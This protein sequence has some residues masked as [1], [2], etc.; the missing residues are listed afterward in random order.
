MQFGKYLRVISINLRE[1]KRGYVVQDGLANVQPNTCLAW[2]VQIQ[3]SIEQ[4]PKS[5]TSTPLVH[6]WTN[7]PEGRQKNESN[8]TGPI[9][10]F[11]HNAKSIT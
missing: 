9:F 6:K 8:D 4:K 5:E 2:E 3:K 10:P 1:K 7:I 11:S